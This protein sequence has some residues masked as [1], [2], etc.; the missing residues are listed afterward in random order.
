MT[1]ENNRVRLTLFLKES[2][3]PTLAIVTL[4]EIAQDTL[5]TWSN[6]TTQYDD[7]NG[8]DRVVP[9]TM[10]ITGVEGDVISF[11]CE[12]VMGM[13]WQAEVTQPQVLTPQGPQLVNPQGQ[14]VGNA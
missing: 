2:A 12:S 3:I 9:S 13:V 4:A 11:A 5:N 6:Y 10:Y 7:G 14:P 1:T 8:D